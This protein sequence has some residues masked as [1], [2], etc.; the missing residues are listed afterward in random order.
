VSIL[1][2][3]KLKE[4]LDI[5]DHIQPVAYLCVGHTESFYNKP[6]LET[7]G[8]AQRL[9]VEKLIYYNKWQGDPSDYRVH[10]SDMGE[11]D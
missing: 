2:H 5:P 6:M 3:D 1:S 9:P 7:A 11:N 10:F 4:D 8:W